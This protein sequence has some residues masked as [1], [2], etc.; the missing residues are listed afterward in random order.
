[1]TAPAPLLTPPKPSKPQDSVGN[2][3]DG[4]FSSVARR[5]QLIALIIGVIC[6]V[7]AQVLESFSLGPQRSA[8]VQEN[9]ASL[10]SLSVTFPRLTLGGFRGLV[11]TALWIQAEDDKENRRWFDLE[12]KYDL[13]ASLQ[14]YFTSV[15]IFHAWNQAYNLSAQWHDEDTKYKWVLDGLAYL[16]GGERYIPHNPDLALEEA[17]MYYLKL[18]GSFERIFFRAHLRS[19]LGRL[20]ELEDVK[21]KEGNAKDSLQ[22]VKDFATRPE[23]HIKLLPD[24]SQ[25]S[26]ALGYGISI[27]DA[28]LFKYRTDGKRAEE[29]VDFPFGVSPFYFA[30]VSFNRSLSFGTAS[31]TGERVIDSEPGMSL[32]LWCRDDLNYGQ[33]MM[34][35]AFNQNSK[36]IIGT[37]AALSAKVA[38]V[39]LCYRN[40]QMIAPKAVDLLKLHLLKW[41]PDLNVHTKH[42][43]ET[44]AYQ[45]IGVAESKLLDALVQWQI[46]GRKMTDKVKQMLLDTLPAYDDAIT[47]TQSWVDKTFPLKEGEA[48]PAERGDIA[49]YV[50]GLQV[51]KQGIQ[52]MLKADP[53]TKPDMS[54][55]EAEVVER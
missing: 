23:F 45:K 28:D 44:Q 16:Y 25:R 54:F 3:R 41:P 6:M 27:T 43:Y 26:K 18:G 51:R 31:T 39:R 20:H 24:P 40:V 53:S 2:G 1:M 32:R 55:L 37:D 7:G 33:D 22:H 50:G 4:F 36:E 8:L 12:T 21:L 9:E 11:S 46:D 17:N 38:E 14:P 5:D 13:I 29:P 52:D 42:I 30:Y 35:A 49:Q 48:P 10:Q 15:Y 34:N 19:D 47:A